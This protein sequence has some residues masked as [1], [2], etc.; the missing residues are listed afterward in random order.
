[1]WFKDRALAN[2]GRLVGLSTACREG[3][4]GE[5]ENLH[6]QQDRHVSC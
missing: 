4:S 2:F 5:T 3:T 1:M 6:R